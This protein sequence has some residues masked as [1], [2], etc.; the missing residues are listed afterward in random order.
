MSQK[1]SQH[2]AGQALNQV[3]APVLGELADDP[4]ALRWLGGH[5]ISAGALLLLKQVD[6]AH[7]AKLPRDFAAK[8]EAGEFDPP[9]AGFGAT[10]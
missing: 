8:I 2:R 7:T 4:L 3:L 6:A 10:Q 5:L 1:D 9:G